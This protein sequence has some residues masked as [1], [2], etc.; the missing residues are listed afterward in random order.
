MA[1]LWITLIVFLVGPSK[2]PEG[3]AN[4]NYL[5]PPHPLRWC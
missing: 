5:A 1:F 2:P 3:P 4:P